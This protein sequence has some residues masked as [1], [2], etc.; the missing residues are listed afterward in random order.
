MI[1]ALPFY[2]LRLVDGGIRLIFGDW[3]TTISTFGIPIDPWATLVCLGVLLGLELARARAIKLG[4]AVEDI[5]DGVVFT[6]LMGFFGAHLITVLAYH[7]ERLQEDGIWAIL[8]VWEGF[9]STGGWMGAAF[10]IWFFY[11]K[12]RPR[13][14]WRFADII[15]YGFPLGWFFGRMGCA[16]VH[17]HIGRL[18]DSPLGVEFPAN[19]FAAGTRFELGLLEMMWT[20]P[21]M[22]LFLWL[23]R[24][25]QPPGTFL[26]LFFLFY[27]PTRFFLDSLRQTDIA[28]ADARYF[29][30]TPAQ[31]GCFALLSFS[32]WILWR[33]D[34][35]NFRPWPMDHEPDQARRAG[36]EANA[37]PG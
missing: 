22:L 25:D 32:L 23:G 11:R 37:E 6:V 24:K 3:S 7:P 27:A 9:S 33:R 28:Y 15:A 2:E 30:L 16:S 26:G 36:E 31:F 14:M 18:T 5:V 19:H 4:L 1:A 29:G 20:V 17:D 21:V 12:W 34:V 13:D 35:K 10:G 8:K